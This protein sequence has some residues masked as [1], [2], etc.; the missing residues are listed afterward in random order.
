MVSWPDAPVKAFLENSELEVASNS[1]MLG[2]A[3]DR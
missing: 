2:D 3:W 1:A